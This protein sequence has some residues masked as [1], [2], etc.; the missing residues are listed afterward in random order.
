THEG[1]S[2]S[3]VPKNTKTPN[4]PKVIKNVNVYLNYT[5]PSIVLDEAHP[6]VGSQDN[7]SINGTSNVTGDF[8]TKFKNLLVNVVGG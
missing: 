2:P 5:G 6:T 4:D 1:A 8:N 7:T 3:A